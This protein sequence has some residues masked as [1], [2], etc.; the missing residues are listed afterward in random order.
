MPVLLIILWLGT[1]C[2]AILDHLEKKGG[3][4]VSA[5]D[6]A[7][8]MVRPVFFKVV[9]VNYRGYTTATMLLPIS[10]N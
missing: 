3:G 2:C 7:N 6:Q 1:N 9:L 4:V 8:D 5:E 10:G